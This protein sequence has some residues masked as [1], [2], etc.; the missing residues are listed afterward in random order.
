MNSKNF[1][2]DN[3][4]NLT[5]G[6]AVFEKNWEDSAHYGLAA[7]T[8]IPTTGQNTMTHYLNKLIITQRLLPKQ[9]FIFQKNWQ[10]R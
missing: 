10:H 9:A 6:R 3:L 4:Q 1:T 8:G 2:L 5:L 7:N